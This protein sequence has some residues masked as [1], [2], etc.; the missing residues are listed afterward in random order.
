V[1]GSTGASTG[2]HL[3]YEVRIDGTAVDAIPFMAARGVTLG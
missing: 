3:H 2:C 1:V